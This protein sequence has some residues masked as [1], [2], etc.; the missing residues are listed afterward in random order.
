MRE[1]D[2]C[3][4]EHPPLSEVEA[5][6]ESR[7]HRWREVVAAVQRELVPRAEPVS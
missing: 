7:C 6:H 2:G 5:G 4:T 3:T 1:E